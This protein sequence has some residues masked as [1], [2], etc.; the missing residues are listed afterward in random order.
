M[1]WPRPYGVQH[2]YNLAATITCSDKPLDQLNTNFGI[3]SIRLKQNKDRLGKNFHFEINNQP[4]KIK[5]ANWLPPSIFPGSA[6]S[7][8]YQTLL[9]QAADANINML[10]VWAGG[11]YENPEFYDLCDRLGILIW[12]DFMFDSAYYPDRKF[13]TEQVKSEAQNIIKQLRN[14]PSLALWCGNNKIDSL[15]AE[16]K[17]AQSKKFYGK[18][19]Y[20]KLLPKL[21]SELDP[22]RDYIPTT[23]AL[24]DKTKKKPNRTPSPANQWNVWKKSAP[25]D[26]YI[27]PKED[28]LRF[29]TEFGLQSIPNLTTLKTFCPKQ[30]LRL[31]AHTLEKHNY[32]PDGNSQIARY[33]NDL[34]GYPKN[35][36]DG[37]YLSQLTQAR[38][39]K[40]YIEYLRTAASVNTG[41][42]F[43]HFNDCCPAISFA[44]IDY[45]KQPKALYY[46]TKRA[47]APISV[48]LMSDGTP[49]K[50][51]SSGPFKYKAARV[52]N[53]SPQ[54]TAATLNSSLLHL[55]GEVLDKVSFPVMLA[56]FSQSAPI[57]LPTEILKPQNPEHS[58]LR[59]TFKDHKKILAQ[60]T[61]LFLPD[62]YID[63]PKPEIT[64]T[65]TP[66]AK[67]QCI[68]KIK[69][70]VVAKD[71]QIST[72]MPALL[73]DNFLT[74]LP[75]SER[76]L[77]V[78][79]EQT[80]L[81]TQQN[82]SF[83][84]VGDS[85]PRKN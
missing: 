23:P 41:V 60:N 28:I 2:L 47:F 36:E 38:A 24:P 62:K 44:A 11:C 10:R 70:N 63:W 33:L 26:D 51:Q 56:P 7:T 43:W 68:L 20:H 40:T 12:Q 30:E 84:S 76:K 82:Y 69:T 18:N 50:K 48:A 8:D 72:D 27:Q 19:I 53:D 83:R 75:D 34:F 61:Y 6:A 64:T 66:T 46:Y 3:S 80:P 32:D 54:S 71:V 17:L 13:F 22:D 14:H 74:L 67:N 15:H 52:V 25:V 73:S 45:L 59:L 35:L 5:G 58:L 65:M 49:S 31:A 85:I 29:V 37:I 81:T 78:T 77:K 39:A 4:I 55:S 57:K 16:S 42:L 21:I 9:K 1:W 79:F